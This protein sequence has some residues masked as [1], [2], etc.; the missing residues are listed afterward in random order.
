ML[1]LYIYFMFK[2]Q[3]DD[4]ESEKEMSESERREWDEEQKV[5]FI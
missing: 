2:G 1:K 5:V 3:R 4:K